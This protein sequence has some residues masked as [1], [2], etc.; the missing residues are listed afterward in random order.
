MLV[1]RSV[2][3]RLCI[4]LAL[5]YLLGTVLGGIGLGWIAL[6]PPSPPIHETE[7]RNAQTAAQR[8]SVE[9]RDTEGRLHASNCS[10]QETIAKVQ[11]SS[12]R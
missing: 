9:F 10:T 1:P 7:E 5:L 2:L 8:T 11:C 12:Q 6:H 4:T 3:S